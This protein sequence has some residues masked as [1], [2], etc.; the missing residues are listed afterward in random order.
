VTSPPLFSASTPA[1]VTLTR[2]ADGTVNGYVNGAHQITFTDGGLVATFTHAGHVGNFGVDDNA[3]GQSEASGG[4]IREIAI[5]DVS[6]TP[7]EV[8]AL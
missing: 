7:A 5:W 3:T 1:E 2:D 8:A 6:L 4:V